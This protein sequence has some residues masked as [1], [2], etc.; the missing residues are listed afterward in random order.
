M[1]PENAPKPD[2][3]ELTENQTPSSGLRKVNRVLPITT[4]VVAGVL[5][6]GGSIFTNAN[7]ESS[8]NADANTVVATP[9]PEI[10]PAASSETVIA[11]SQQST[12]VP[13]IAPQSNGEGF[14]RDHEGR[15]RPRHGERPEG[16]FHHERPD[17]EDRDHDEDHEMEDH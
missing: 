2:W 17:H 10:T 6:L 5:I 4:L 14:G 12:G 11:P 8:A 16:E 3:F 1:T 9:S 15:E 13:T 7:G